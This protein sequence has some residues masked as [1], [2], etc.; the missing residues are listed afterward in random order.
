M[1]SSK[2]IVLVTLL[3]SAVISA[4]EQSVSIASNGEWSPG[5]VSHITIEY[6]ATN[7]AATSGLG[8]RIHFN[9]YELS[10]VGFESLLSDSLVAQSA[11]SL[12]DINDYDNNP[13]TDKYI[14]IAWA[15]IN[16]RWPSVIS[17]P[18]VLADIAFT[19]EEFLGRGPVIELSAASVANG[20]EFV[21]K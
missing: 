16:S 19:A 2:Y 6:Q 10:F 14:L 9:S 7:D 13:N 12:P 15:D 18:V 17:S 11:A 4:K 8:L 21:V 20:F 3:F 5:L 1:F